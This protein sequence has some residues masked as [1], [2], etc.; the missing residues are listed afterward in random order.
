MTSKRPF[1]SS[2]KKILDALEMCGEMTV[3]DICQHIAID[4]DHVST[5]LTR[6]RKPLKSMDQRVY[7]VRYVYDAEGLRRY[8]RPMYALGNKPNAKKPKPDKKEIKRRY[9][10]KLRR[11]MTGNSVFNLG[12]T[13]RQYQEMRAA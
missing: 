7:I 13:R 12:L 3:E 4:R 8:P 1:G 9:N 6:M 2:V 10:A 11:L 5:I